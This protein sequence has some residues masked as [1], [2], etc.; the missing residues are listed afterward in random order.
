MNCPNI[1]TDEALIPKEDRRASRTRCLFAQ[2]FNF[3]RILSPRSF[4]EDAST[5]Q[6]PRRSRRKTQ[7]IH[8]KC[9]TL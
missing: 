8:R 5:C 3:L 1:L 7:I 2:A 6:R 4:S 9:M